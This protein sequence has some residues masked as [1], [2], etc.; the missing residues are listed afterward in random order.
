[1]VDVILPV[2]GRRVVQIACPLLFLPV[3]QLTFIYFQRL[4]S[5]FI[6]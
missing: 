2:G 6:D 4:T 3:V 1:M 5:V